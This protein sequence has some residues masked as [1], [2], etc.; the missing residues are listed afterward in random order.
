MSFTSDHQEVIPC[1]VS[2]GCSANDA[3]DIRS[4]DTVSIVVGECQPKSARWEFADWKE[5]QW[6]ALLIPLLGLWL[7][8]TRRGL[9]F[10]NRVLTAWLTYQIAYIEDADGRKKNLLILL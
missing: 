3:A 6:T 7:L 2:L 4:E 5:A 8:L 9:S 10:Y 1:I